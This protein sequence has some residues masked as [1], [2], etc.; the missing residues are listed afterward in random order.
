MR[1]AEAKRR[2]KLSS[3]LTKYQKTDIPIFCPHKK[4][5]IFLFTHI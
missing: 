5:K 1:L 4:I 2:Q 3:C